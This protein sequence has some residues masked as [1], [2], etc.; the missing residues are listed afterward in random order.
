MPPA[1]RQIA[2]HELVPYAV[3]YKALN[4]DEDLGL[5]LSAGETVV[6]IYR[7]PVSDLDFGLL[8]TSKGIYRLGE[9]GRRFVGYE[10]IDSMD[11]QADKSMMSADRKTRELVLWLTSGESVFIRVSGDKDN[12]T[13]DLYSMWRFLKK[14]VFWT[15]KT[16]KG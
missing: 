12:M 5:S 14:V 13:Y 3:G 15:Q 4:G 10:E 6:G 16:R 2:E 1:I 8:L 9:E 7:D 11:I